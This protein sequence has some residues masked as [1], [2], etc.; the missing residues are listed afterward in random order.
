MEIDGKKVVDATKKLTIRITE[1]D[2]TRGNTKDPGHC[3]AARALLR[4]VPECTRARVHVGR[5]Y[6]LQK[7]PSGREQW[8]KYQTPKALRTEIVAFDRG[9]TFE[10][11]EYTLV[12]I[13]PSAREAF[14][15][16]RATGTQT[17]KTRKGPKI[18][19]VKSHYVSGVRAHGANR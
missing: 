7:T 17:G 10:P 12:P 4:S 16:K 19:R 6:L 9:G 3:A 2:V 8:V 5:T 13:P 18:A 15:A 1:S 14:K 11:G